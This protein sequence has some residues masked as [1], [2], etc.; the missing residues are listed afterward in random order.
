MVFKSFQMKPKNKTVG[1]KNS[2]A[3]SNHDGCMVNFGTV[4]IFNYCKLHNLSL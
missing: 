4:L 2:E 3:E 1:T